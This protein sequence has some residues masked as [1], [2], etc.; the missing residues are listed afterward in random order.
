MDARV[1]FCAITWI[2]L[3]QIW[4]CACSAAVR[5]ANGMGLVMKTKLSPDRLVLLSQWLWWMLRLRLGPD[6]PQ[7]NG[8]DCAEPFVRAVRISAG[9]QSL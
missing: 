6:C 5:L 7:G 2:S 3:V 4:N 9:P 8:S 1:E